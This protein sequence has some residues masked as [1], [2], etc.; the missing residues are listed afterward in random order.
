MWRTCP[1]PYA[2]SSCVQGKCIWY[3]TSILLAHSR[4]SLRRMW[5][6]GTMGRGTKAAGRTTPVRGSERSRGRVV[7][8]TR[9]SGRRASRMATAHFTPGPLALAP[10]SQASGCCCL[11]VSLVLIALRVGVAPQERLHIQRHLDKVHN[12]QHLGACVCTHAC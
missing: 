3:V 4:F 2:C 10:F 7:D 1:P 8:I 12:S 6:A 11:C 9:A 5:T